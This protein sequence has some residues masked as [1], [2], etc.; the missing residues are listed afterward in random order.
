MLFKPFDR[1]RTLFWA[2]FILI[3]IMGWPGTLRSPGSQPDDPAQPAPL[4]KSWRA[5]IADVKKQ[6]ASEKAGLETLYKFLHSH[7]ELSFQEEQTA[8]VMAK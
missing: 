1:S 7:P 3:A 6:I 4:S 8:A 5:R 2:G